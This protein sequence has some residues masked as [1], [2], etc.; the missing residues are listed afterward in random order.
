MT[1]FELEP[2]PEPEPVE[3]LSADRRRTLKRRA[4]IAAGK[5]PG[6]GLPIDT[7]HTCGEC[8]HIIRAHHGGSPR[9]WL[10]CP[11]Y[12]GHTFG[13][14]T[15]IRASWPACPHFEQRIGYETTEPP[16][17]IGDGT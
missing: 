4:A 7:A 1:L 11:P 3:V 2:V 5:H 8:K 16:V 10:K 17:V 6:N 13:A 9:S 12:V 14:A 15:D